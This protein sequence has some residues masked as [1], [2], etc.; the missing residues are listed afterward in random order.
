MN[1]YQFILIVNENIYSLIT[2]HPGVLASPNQF[3][4]PLV[5]W[6][7]LESPRRNYPEDNLE[8]HLGPG[9]PLLLLP[10]G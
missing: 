4:L 1:F 7:R 2:I 8:A 9:L 3:L 6:R 5:F 10:T